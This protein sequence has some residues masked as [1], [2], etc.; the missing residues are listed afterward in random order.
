VERLVHKQNSF[1]ED[2]FLS[3]TSAHMKNIK[4]YYSLRLL[5]HLSEEQAD[6]IGAILEMANTD[7]VINFWINEID[8]SHGH[9]LNF[10]DNASRHSY[11]NQQALLREYL[12]QIDL[13]KLSY[14]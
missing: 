13:L 10:L 3:C 1:L 12:G 6:R 9:R 7:D 5:P 14:V 8:H 11:K 2:H 4:D